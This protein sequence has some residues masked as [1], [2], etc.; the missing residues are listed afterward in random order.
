MAQLGDL[1]LEASPNAMILAATASPGVKASKVLEV[2]Q[3]LGIERLHVTRRDDDLVQPYITSME[4]NKHDL[5]LPTELLEIIRP[6]RILQA[7]EAEFLTRSGFLINSGRITTAAIE[8]AQR[9]ASAAIGRGDPRGY[10]GAKRIGDLR[11]LHRLLDLLD[12]QG[13]KCAV[14]YLERARQDKDRKTKRFL[15]L[16]Q[17]AE[18]LSSHKLTGNSIQNLNWL[19]NWLRVD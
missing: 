13:L 7:E 4:V 2:I 10:D 3:R 1:Y 14:K 18:F 12:T 8:E 19:Q 16:P 17:V 5:N 9:R 11:R 6:L 15:S